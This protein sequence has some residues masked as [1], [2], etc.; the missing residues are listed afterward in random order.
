[1]KERLVKAERQTMQRSSCLIRGDD[2]GED[3]TAPAYRH[4]RSGALI[5]E[6]KAAHQY[7]DH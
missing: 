3:T 2:T 6:T 5:A 7:H 4:H 1:M